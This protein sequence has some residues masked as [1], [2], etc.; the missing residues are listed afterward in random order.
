M[1]AWRGW[2]GW[3]LLGL[4]QLAQAQQGISLSGLLGGQYSHPARTSNLPQDDWVAPRWDW[5]G[6]LAATG[7]GVDPA[8]L[9]WAAQ[10]DYSGW[11]ERFGPS[12]SAA[13]R[14]GFGL[15]AHLLSGLS[16]PIEL[17]APRTFIRTGPSQW[18]GRTRLTQY[19]GRVALRRPDLP[20]AM[21]SLSRAI[22]DTVVAGDHRLSFASTA[23]SLAA[24]QNRPGLDYAASYDTSWNSGWSADRNYRSHQVLLRAG[25]ELAK[26]TRLTV[27]ERYYLR[28][29]TVAASFN[30]RFDENTFS[31]QLHWTQGERSHTSVGYTFS[32]SLVTGEAN[33]AIEQNNQRLLHRSLTALTPTLGVDWGLGAS[34]AA[35]RLGEAESKGFGQQANGGLYWNPSFRWGTLITQG[36]A[37]VGLVEP[38]SGAV[39]LA[40]GVGGKL[41]ASSQWRSVEGLL[42]YSAQYTY[43]GPAVAGWILGQ[44][45]HASVAQS[46][47]RWRVRAAGDANL[48][49]RED[50]LLGLFY[51]RSAVA[52]LGLGWRSVEATLDAGQTHGLSESLT[53]PG[54][55]G[56]LFLPA[57]YNSQVTF[58]GVTAG[59]SYDLL[60]VTASARFSST[61]AP[62]TPPLTGRQLCLVARVLVGRFTLS[63]QDRYTQER[64]GE[65]WQNSNQ[66][67]V[68]LERSFG[69]EL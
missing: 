6:A 15:N 35:A 14:V 43:G 11:R 28:L 41:G 36:S 40:R 46:G 27:D 4:G 31:A 66:F 30:P 7:G 29:P 17:A 18:V 26:G 23:L 50:R 53:A 39:L 57:R 52:T 8:L 19:L 22:N 34:Y 60:G 69:W 48:S 10:V 49:R 47:R 65:T 67:W 45:L 62:E 64:F 37:L 68:T 25:A 12:S 51:N 9:A 5:T 21:L 16:G 54:S 3:L 63:L 55:F 24:Y 58:A 38:S 44:S 56:E 1:S 42:Y 33:P 32:R 2:S 61:Q 59:G 20:V 13:D